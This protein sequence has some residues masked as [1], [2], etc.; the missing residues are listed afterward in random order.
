MS[1]LHSFRIESDSLGNMPIP[2]NVLWGIHT[3]RAKANFIQSR[4][5]QFPYF[6]KAL[7]QVKLAAAYA[8]QDL[9]YLKSPIAPAVIQ[10]LEEMIQG[11]WIDHFITDAIQGGAGT[12]TNMNINEITAKRAG[13]I[14]EAQGISDTI[15]PIAHINLHQST[16]DVYPTAIKIAAYYYLMDL[17]TQLN[18]LLMSLQKKEKEFAGFIKLGRTE[19][20]PAIPTT[21]GKTFGA[22]ADAIARDR[23]RI[24]KCEERIR[25]INLGGTAIGTGLGA[26]RAYIFKVSDHLKTITALPLARAENL[27]DATQNHDQIAEVFAMIKVVALNLEK[28]SHDLRYMV[29]VGEITLQA[30]QVG[31]SI[32]PGKFNPVILEM[33]SIIAKK[34]IGN[35]AIACQCIAS[36]ELELNAFLPLVSYTLFES[37]DMLIQGL[38]KFKTLCI[39]SIQINPNTNMQFILNTPTSAT[40][41]VGKIGYKKAAEV[42]EYMIQNHT[43]LKTAA[44]ALSCIS[45]SDFTE[46]LLPE[47]IC[48]LG[49]S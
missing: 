2:Q 6:Y 10:A 32:M 23:W 31:S 46:F 48:Q 44:L 19:L 34:V 41:L 29:S 13:Q 18:E 17:E 49:H 26:P 12:S 21:F 39:D 36:G 20:M 22:F 24:F 47:K 35:E 42:A 25:Q 45:E 14:L 37:C 3:A 38:E 8:N 27:I 28:I 16:N 15:D 4:L 40:L 9:G 30:L 1:D 5:P 7:A 43:D 33:V 11:Q